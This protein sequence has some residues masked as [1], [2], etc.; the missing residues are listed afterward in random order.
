L[1]AHGDDRLGDKTPWGLIATTEGQR[2]VESMLWQI[3]EGMYG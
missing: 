2:S 1:A 3:D